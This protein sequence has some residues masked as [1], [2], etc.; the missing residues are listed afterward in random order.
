MLQQH[1]THRLDQVELSLRRAAERH[2]GSLLATSGVGNALAFTLCFSNLYEPMLMADPRFASF[3]PCRIA[4]WAKGD[5]VMLETISPREYCR[6][7]HRPDLE[8]LAESLEGILRRVMEDAARRTSAPARPDEER[9]ATED[10][11]NMRAALPQRLDRHGTKVEELAG[12]GV[13]DA[14]GG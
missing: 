14:Q 4:A 8:R 5:G 12:T 3:L 7:L 2:D 13:H 9:A 11:V 6:L 1:S 10:Q